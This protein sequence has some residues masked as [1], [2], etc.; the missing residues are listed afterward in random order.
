M[1]LTKRRRDKRF[2]NFV[3]IPRKVLE[4]EA[5]K[6]FSSSAK[7]FYI[8]LKGRYNGQNN[9]HIRLYY[10][11][12]K[13]TKG[14]SSPGTISRASSELQA[15]GWITRRTLGGLHRYFNEYELTGKV[16][17]YL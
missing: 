12:L 15:A 11:G 7:L 6:H 17:D 2:N 14:L 9:G 8:Y 5:W 16:D 10:N 4:D 3:M 1:S 13:G